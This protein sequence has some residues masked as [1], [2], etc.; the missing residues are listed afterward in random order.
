MCTLSFQEASYENHLQSV[1]NVDADA[2]YLLLTAKL[3]S[4]GELSVIRQG[5]RGAV[6]SDTHCF[7][8]LIAWLACLVSPVM[9]TTDYA[10]ICGAPFYVVSLQQSWHEGQLK[11]DVG[12]ISRTE[13]GDFLSAQHANGKLKMKANN[14]FRHAVS[15]FLS[16]N[17]LQS[18]YNRL[19][20][21]TPCLP[22]HLKETQMSKKNL[23]TSLTV[24]PDPET[25]CRVFGAKPGFFWQ[26]MEMN[27]APVDDKTGE[28]LFQG[29]EIHNAFMLMHSAVFRQPFCLLDVL[30]RAR[31]NALDIAGIRLVY[32]QNEVLEEKPGR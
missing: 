13:N 27:D 1:P 30:I 29:P 18:V 32:P 24:N 28:R 23:S 14:S 12:I 21:H 11:V 3:S 15:K 26:T 4:C 2:S 20:E 16:T 25:M 5:V 8:H 19:L 31:C 7:S 6:S 10:E 9:N 17:T 22:Q